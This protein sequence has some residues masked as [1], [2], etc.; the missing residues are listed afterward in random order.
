MSLLAE[1]AGVLVDGEARAVVAI[2]NRAPPG[3]R[4]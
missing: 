4:K 3:S 2:S 1:G